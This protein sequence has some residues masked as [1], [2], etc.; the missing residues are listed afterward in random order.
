MTHHPISD[1]IFFCCLIWLIIKGLETK[2]FFSITQDKS[3]NNRKI[4]KRLNWPHICVCLGKD[5]TSSLYGVT[6]SCPCSL[7]KEIV[8]HF[9]PD[10]EGYEVVQDA[11]DTMT[12]VAWYINDM[13]RKHEHA[14]RVQVRWNY[15]NC[16][17]TSFLKKCI[18]CMSMPWS[19]CIQSIAYST[20]SRCIFPFSSDTFW[21]SH[22]CTVCCPRPL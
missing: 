12:G 19:A 5:L 3:D 8:K 20:E 18:Y 21:F 10:E 22:A 16:K 1:F 15:N 9:D 4:W 6:I 7:L 11:I 13:K 17:P 14:V 2:C